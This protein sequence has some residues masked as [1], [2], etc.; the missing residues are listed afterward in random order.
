[1]F[2]LYRMSRNWLDKVGRRWFRQGRE[3]TEIKA[4]I[5]CMDV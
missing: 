2:N 1:M 4:Q 5:F 3:Q